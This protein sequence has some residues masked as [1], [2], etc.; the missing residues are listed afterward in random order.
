MLTISLLI[1]FYHRRDA[2]AEE[3]ISFA[4]FFEIKNLFLCGEI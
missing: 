4:C 2:E 3:N 1:L